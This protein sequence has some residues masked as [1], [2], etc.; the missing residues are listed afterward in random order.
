M[1]SFAQSTYSIN[2][3]AGTVEVEVTV[4]EAFDVDIAVHIVTT[5]ISATG[6]NND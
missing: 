2:E 6:I 5:N 4:S 1:I 3:S